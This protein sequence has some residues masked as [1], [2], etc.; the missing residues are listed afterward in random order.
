MGTIN[1][2]DGRI[3]TVTG[4]NKGQQQP[5]QRGGYAPDSRSPPASPGVMV[6]WGPG[7]LS[8]DTCRAGSTA[9]LRGVLRPACRQQRGNY[10]ETPPGCSLGREQ[11]DERE[12]SS[13]CV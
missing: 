11:G 2:Y 3:V 6:R 9:A 7:E 4:S 5:Q 8:V 13:P 10:G 1:E 12:G